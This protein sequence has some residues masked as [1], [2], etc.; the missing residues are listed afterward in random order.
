MSINVWVLC[1]KSRWRVET[2]FQHSLQED[3]EIMSLWQRYRRIFFYRKVYCNTKLMGTLNDTLT[4]SPP[5]LPGFQRGRLFTTRNASLSRAGSTLRR[6]RA[7]VTKPSFP[8]TKLTYTFPCIPFSCAI[9]GYLIAWAM[10]RRRANS[11][12]GTSGISSTMKKNGYSFFSSSFS[13]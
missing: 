10:N 11:P 5:C 4:F 9:T 3:F 12:P 7:S 13:C 8:T 6:M 2:I 1:Q